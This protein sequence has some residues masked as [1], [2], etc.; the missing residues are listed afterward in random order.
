LHT[1][2]YIYLLNAI[3][4]FLGII[5]GLL[6]LGVLSAGAGYYF[7]VTNLSAKPSKP[8]FAEERNPKPAVK[9]VAKKPSIKPSQEPDKKEEKEE[10]TKKEKPLPPGAYGATVVWETGVSLRKEPTDGS[11]KTGGVG[12]K[13]K[14]TVLKETADKSWVQVRN[15]DA[16]VEGWLKAGN[17]E[18]DAD[19]N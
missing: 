2:Q 11:E 5:L 6:T 19:G 18:R 1:Y 12:F 9:P 7:F 3:K 16:T 13:E 10:E 4:I 15:A 8:S 17:V 14:I